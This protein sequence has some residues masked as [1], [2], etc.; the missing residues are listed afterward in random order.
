MRIRAEGER[1]EDATLSREKLTVQFRKERVFLLLLKRVFGTSHTLSRVSLYCH[2]SSLSFFPFCPSVKNDTLLPR[3][4]LS[5]ASTVY[6][7]LTTGASHFVSGR[8][9]SEKMH[10]AKT[11]MKLVKVRVKLRHSICTLQS[12]H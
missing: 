11:K 5:T 3:V 10:K 8:T 1:K 6:K 7:K 4:H 12:S 9:Q 2:W